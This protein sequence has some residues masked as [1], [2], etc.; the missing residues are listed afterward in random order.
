MAWK[1]SGNH[2]KWGNLLH[3]AV[4]MKQVKTCWD[5]NEKKNMFFGGLRFDPFS[6]KNLGA[7]RIVGFDLSLER[8]SQ[9]W[10]A[11]D[12]TNQESLIWINPDQ[13]PT[14][15]KEMLGHLPLP[16]PSFQWRCDVR[17]LW[18]IQIPT[19]KTSAGG[20]PVCP[21]MFTQWVA[22]KVLF[23]TQMDWNRRILW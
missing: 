20:T 11:T 1:L 21:M 2:E 18:F 9:A 23:T 4:K 22:V 3:P 14:W 13:S 12:T 16:S 17:S 8:C 19:T 5:E 15:N 7:E 6:F 10:L